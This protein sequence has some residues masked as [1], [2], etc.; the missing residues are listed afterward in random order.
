LDYQNNKIGL[1]LQRDKFVTPFIGVVVLIRFVMWIFIL[2]NIYDLSVG[3]CFI[4]FALPVQKCYKAFTNRIIE[5]R[6]KL[7]TKKVKGTK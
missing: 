2:G 4:C 5:S 3:C 7:K 1:S 6:N